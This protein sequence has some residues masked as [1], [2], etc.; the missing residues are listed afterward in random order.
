ML[1]TQRPSV[2]VITGVI[3]AN[4][5][6]RIAFQVVSK[7]DS[8]TILDQIGAERLLGKGDMLFQSPGTIKP[9][10]LQGAFVSEQEIESL[11]VRLK[12]DHPLSYFSSLLENLSE[13]N[14]TGI[15]KELCNDPMWQQAIELAE[16]KGSISAS[17]LQRRL[18]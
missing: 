13:D 17:Y 11:L 5:P 2:D 4:F 15:D 6:A 9:Q 3:K 10:R 12:N 16:Q 14:K 18:I 8:R 1:A 7:H